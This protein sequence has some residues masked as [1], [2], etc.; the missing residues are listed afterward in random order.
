MAGMYDNAL[1]YQIQQANDIVDLVSE[2][3][4]LA[5][6]GKEMVGLCPF[7]DDHRPSMYVN[8]SKQIFKC[9]ACG[10]GGNVFQFVQMRENLTFGQAIERLAQRAGIKL[11]SPKRT[12]G[13]EQ[14]VGEDIDPN[15]LAKVNAWAAKHFQKNLF[16]SKAGKATLKYLDERQISRESVR[17]WQLGLALES[18]DDLV[19]A[20]RSSKVPS[21]LLQQ[22]GLV[23][24]QGGRF[25]DK[26][27]KRLMFVITDVTGRVIGFG[28]RILDGEGAKYINSP[29]T[30]LFDKSTSLYGLQFARESIVSKGLAVV[31]EGYTDC[32]MS[33][34]K[35]CTN[36]VATLGTSFT[37]G[38]A[39][40]LRRYAK[41]VVLLF[42][43]DIAGME[44]AN[45]AMEVCLSE[46]ID[47][48]L[49]TIPGGKDPCEFLL[50]S[51]KE[52]FEALVEGAVEVFEYKWNRLSEQ[53][54]SDETLRGRKQAMDEF[55]QALAVTMQAYPQAVTDRGL[56][57]NRLSSLLGLETKQINAELSR[58]LKRASRSTTVHRE[59]QKAGKVEIGTGL[60]ATAEREVLEVLLNAPNM[61]EKVRE[62][63]REDFFE[64]TIFRQIAEVVFSTLKEEPGAELGQIMARI[65]SL[66]C[67]SLVAEL[68]QCGEE[69]GNFEH[70]LDE[71]MEVLLQQRKRSEIKAIKDKDKYLRRLAEDAGDENRH[72][73]G[74]IY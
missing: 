52:A 23:V 3:V 60:R 8:G 55:L 63:I 28:G 46:H 66:E 59:N 30:A 72:S 50:D 64:E 21:E 34:V 26:F 12:K 41:T 54:K 32:I 19:G 18:G 58:R 68:A 56:V 2:H 24:Q 31:V 39:R 69:K 7:H 33:H 13:R 11:P 37:N 74:M 36:V 51:G 16:E 9:F 73:L 1:I 45:R 62:K 29:A 35:G 4:N 6:K 49:S 38:H 47:I 25:M 27:V 10:A 44:A 65:E 43:G 48:K 67:G 20:G 14:R 5:R 53:F 40:V 57:I 70:R 17:R 71:A 61:F 15:R 42:D 22:A